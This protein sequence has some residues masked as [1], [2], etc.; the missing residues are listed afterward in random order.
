MVQNH[1]FGYVRSLLVTSCAYEGKTIIIC[2]EVCTV[3]QYDLQHDLKY[4]KKKLKSISIVG[5]IYLNQQASNECLF[6]VD[7]S[8]HGVAPL[9]LWYIHPTNS[10][11]YP[12][13]NRSITS[14]PWPIEQLQV[15]NLR[16][17]CWK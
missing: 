7:T 11:S 14:H 13:E 5:S 17:D 12:L 3:I 15:Y 8:H 6:S 1:V 9:P 4:V 16:E 10:G 2:A